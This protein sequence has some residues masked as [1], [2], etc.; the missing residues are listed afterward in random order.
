MAQL[1]AHGLEVEVPT[2][3]DGAIYVRG[4]TA[5]TDGTTAPD[6]TVVTAPG[7]PP[8][9]PDDASADSDPAATDPDPAPADPDP[10]AEP[11]SSRAVPTPEGEIQ[12]PVVQVANFPLPPDRGDYGGGA[13]EL[14]G[15][16]HLLVC[17]LEQGPESLS[18]DLFGT[19]GRPTLSPDDFDPNRMQRPQKGQSGTQAFFQEADR[20]FILYVALGSHRL[21]R[22]L[23]PVANG[24]VEGLTIE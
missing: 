6:S 9:D 4:G 13:V 16:R 12:R 3:W 11:T 22:M 20:A 2:G 18:T 15:P 23:V 17:L 8:G 21:R 24:I 7:D 5:A 10:P 14:M 19:V 1:Q